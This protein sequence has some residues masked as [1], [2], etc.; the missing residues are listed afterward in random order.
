MLPALIGF[1][2]LY[3]LPTARA[4][5]ISLTDWN[6]LQPARF[7]GLD[8]YTQMLH[9]SRFW[10]GIK[11]SAYDVLLN[12]P[13]QMVLGLFL[14]GLKN[15]PRNLHK[16]AALEGASEWQMFWRITLPLL[17]PVMVFV[18]A[19]RVTG[20]FQ[21]FDTIAITTNGGPLNSTR[22]IVH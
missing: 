16:A 17:R 9:D 22:V 8:N 11:L 4:I 2:A 21:I 13:A 1:L 18:V 7:V 5:Q 20:S 14:A 12:I 19:T 3:A 15:I 10:N 6:L